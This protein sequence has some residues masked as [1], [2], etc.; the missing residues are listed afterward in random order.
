[1]SLNS[2]IDQYVAEQK[3]HQALEKARWGELK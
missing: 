1:M 3:C 2:L